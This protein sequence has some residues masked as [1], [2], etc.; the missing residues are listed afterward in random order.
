MTGLLPPDDD[1]DLIHT[2]TYETRVYLIDDTEVLVR[3]AVSDLKPAGLYVT[4]DPEPLEI[5]Q[6]Q[7]ELT[8]ALPELTI[9]SARVGFESHPAEECPSIAGHYGSLVGLSIS[10]GFTHKVRELFGGPRGCTHAT[11]LLQAMAPAVVQS[12]W[13]VGVRAARQA[14]RAPGAGDPGRARRFAGNLNTCHVWAEDGEHV[15]SLE[16]GETPLPPLQVRRRL[17]ELGRES[18]EWRGEPAAG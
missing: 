4:D 12:M 3:G 1:L 8:V 10:R 5:H 16:R 18:G 2:R 6:M 15:A 13:S 7:V 9:T 17:A 14:G 11:A